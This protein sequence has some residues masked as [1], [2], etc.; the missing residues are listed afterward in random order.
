MRK[1]NVLGKKYTELTG[2]I[3]N[4]TE[5]SYDCDVPVKRVLLAARKNRLDYITL[6]DH[7]VTPDK[8]DIERALSTISQES[9]KSAP[10]QPIVIS[11]AELNDPDD[12][13]H[14]L[15]FSKDITEKELLLPDSLESLAEVKENYFFAAHPYERRLCKDFPLYTWKQTDLLKL[16]HGL[17]IWNF[18]SS[19]LSRLYP[20]VNGLFSL[21]FPNFFVKKPFRESLNLWDDLT[22]Q[23]YKIAGIGSTDA[24]GTKHKLFFI[25]IRILTHKYLFGTIR[26]NVLLEST[27]KVTEKEILD[28]LRRG[29]SYVVNYRLG[30]PYNFSCGVYSAQGEGATFGDEIAFDKNMKFYYTLPSYA[31]VQLVKEGKKLAAQYNKFGEFALTEPGAYR[32]E[33]TRFGFGWIYTNNIYV[34][35]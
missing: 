25:Q 21:L 33:I 35:R 5:Y 30:H 31:R 10:Y 1:V 32:L 6:N 12:S 17:E 27:E 26:T 34:T 23:G 3:H 24:H 16:V 14:L 7:G 11:G 29:R 18:S 19:W 28:A 22:A 9:E 20:K 8:S 15:V 4:H 13:H 2:V